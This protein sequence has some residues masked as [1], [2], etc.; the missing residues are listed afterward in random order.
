M[1]LFDS[2]TGEKIS[3]R[4]VE[5]ASRDFSF[6][7]NWETYQNGMENTSAEEIN[8]VEGKYDYD[9][10]L[11]RTEADKKCLRKI[12]RNSIVKNK[13]TTCKVLTSPISEHHTYL[14]GECIEK[15]FPRTF[16]MLNK[17]TSLE[18]KLPI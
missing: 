16:G 1:D 14:P 8:F 15:M 17:M 2:E 11:H 3:G 18:N 13:G 9:V 4:Y 10:I 5:I 6:Y 7:L 12:K